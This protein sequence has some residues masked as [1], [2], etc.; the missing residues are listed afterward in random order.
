MKSLIVDTIK[1]NPSKKVSYQF[2]Y[3]LSID[4]TQRFSLSKIYILLYTK[5]HVYASKCNFISFKMV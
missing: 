4:N 3:S 5:K 2:K 1:L